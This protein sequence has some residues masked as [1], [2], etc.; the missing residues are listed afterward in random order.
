[1][2]VDATRPGPVRGQVAEA[3][4]EQLEF[5]DHLDPARMDTE[6]RL[7]DMLDDPSALVRFWCAFGLGKLRTTAAV[8]LL[9]KLKTDTTSVP[10]WWTVGEE[11]ADAIETIEGRQPSERVGRK[12]N[13]R[14]AR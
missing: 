8:P 2:L 7:I 3:V 5:S 1:V 9:R 14:R 4:A 12:P 11:A 10:G 6:A 13:R